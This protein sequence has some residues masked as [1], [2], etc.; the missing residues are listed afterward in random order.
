MRIG[1]DDDDMFVDG[2]FVDGKREKVVGVAGRGLLG[3]SPCR[4]FWMCCSGFSI[5][6]A[7][8]GKRSLLTHT[9]TNS[10]MTGAASRRALGSSVA[11]MH[12]SSNWKYS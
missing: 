2:V 12:S 3:T 8:K 5:A 1:G 4:W 9:R 10:S 7:G 6:K 11:T